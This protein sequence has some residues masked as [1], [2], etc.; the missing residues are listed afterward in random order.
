MNIYHTWF[1][2]HILNTQWIVWVISMTIF[3]L[4]VFS[5]LVLWIAFS[6]KSKEKNK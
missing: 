2:M 5:V 6:S 1:Y 4:N 3:I